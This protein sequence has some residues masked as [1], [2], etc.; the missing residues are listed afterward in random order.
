MSWAGLDNFPATSLA[1]NLDKKLLVIL[2]DGKKIIGIL[3]S[4]D[5]F[6]NV[7]LEGALERITVGELYCDLPLGLYIIR[8]ENVVL[9]GELDLG[10]E[11][12]PSF[13][14]RV[15]PTE[16]KQ[17]QKAEKDA[18]ELKGTMRKRME[19]LDLE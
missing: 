3:R 16:I 13:M 18:T 17:A 1:D 11:E 6:A 9:I 19:F 15:T 7:V 10:R 14:V 12:L 5:Q 2:R 4:F 8:G